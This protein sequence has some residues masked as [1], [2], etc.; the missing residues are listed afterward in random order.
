VKYSRFISRFDITMNVA[1]SRKISRSLFAPKNI[2][3]RNKK[4]FHR[5]WI[6]F[7]VDRMM[8]LDWWTLTMVEHCLSQAPNA[9]LEDEEIPLKRCKTWEMLGEDQTR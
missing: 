7:G 3:S 6:V 1:V 4:F 2:D 8:A 5:I 9:E